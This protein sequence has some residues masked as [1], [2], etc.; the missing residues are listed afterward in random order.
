MSD[1]IQMALDH[2]LVLSPV[3][4]LVPTPEQL[5][6]FRAAVLKDYR[7]SMQTA[8]AA[9]RDAMPTP[10]PSSELEGAWGQ[11]MGD[12]MSV[13]DYVSASV[14]AL[15]AERD[16]LR[17]QLAKALEFPYNETF[18]AIAAATNNPYP[19]AIGISVSAF[20]TA[21]KAAIAA[22]GKT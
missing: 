19:D 21:Y 12:S 5:A 3:R 2:G 17:D 1:L 9:C 22:G 16:A 4:G 10:E 7:D 15:K 13:P 18:S 14:A 11:A 8:L 20:K 6:A